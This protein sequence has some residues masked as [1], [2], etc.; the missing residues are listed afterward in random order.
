MFLKKR[1]PRWA[2]NETESGVEKDIVLY[3]NLSFA[4]F[5]CFVTD[6]LM[7]TK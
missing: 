5:I 6:V 1:D 2:P 4:P 7:S 3:P